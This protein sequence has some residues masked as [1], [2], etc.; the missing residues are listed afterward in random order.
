MLYSTS[1]RKN[2]TDRNK[3]KLRKTV[4]KKCS[5]NFSAFVGF[6]LWHQLSFIEGKER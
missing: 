2:K 3:S 4:R 6:I 5:F 1:L